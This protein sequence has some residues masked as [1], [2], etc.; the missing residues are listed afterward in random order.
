[1]DHKRV[2]PSELL[3]TVLALEVLLVRMQ[4]GYVVFKI[5]PL[6]ELLVAVFT[7]VGFVAGMESQVD[8]QGARSEEAFAAL[9][10]LV[11]SNAR[12]AS[13]VVHQGVAVGEDTVA[14]RALQRCFFLVSLVGVFDYRQWGR[15]WYIQKKSGELFK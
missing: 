15:F 3:P 6:P 2:F 5:T 10:A 8:F 1:M 13:H 9:L 4:R 11:R 7:V 12:V 14:F